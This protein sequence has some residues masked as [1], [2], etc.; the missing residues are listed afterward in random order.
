MVERPSP[1]LSE[2]SPRA[3]TPA[4]RADTLEAAP[5]RRRRRGNVGH[6]RATVLPDRPRRSQADS[7]DRIDSECL[8]NGG[9]LHRDERG[10]N[11]I[12]RWR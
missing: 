6:R 1:D 9:Q 7:T 2:L 10:P 4:L 5:G 12:K 8:N 11:L 3:G